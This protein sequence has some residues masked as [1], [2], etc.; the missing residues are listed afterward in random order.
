M[1]SFARSVR[2]DSAHCARTCRRRR[3]LSTSQALTLTHSIAFR[4][5]V[6]I[7]TEAAI[8]TF[9]ASLM[10]YFMM[11]AATGSRP[12]YE[13]YLDGTPTPHCPQP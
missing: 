10:T 7:L 5:D 9:L 6:R 2:K 13:H 11:D 1:P 12:V 3:I 8:R 4:H